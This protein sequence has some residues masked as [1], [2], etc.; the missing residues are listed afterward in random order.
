MSSIANRMPP[1]RT[2]R[3]TVLRSVGSTVLARLAA[4]LV[5]AA[6]GVVVTRMVIDQYGNAAYGQYMLLVSVAALLPFA[7]LGISAA[8]VN[9]TAA[10]DDP[11]RDEYLR[12]TLVSCYRILAVCAVVGLLAVLIISAL[13][14]WRRL[15]GSGLHGRSGALAAALCMVVFALNLLV[16]GGERILTGLRLN[17]V[18]VV[19]RVVQ[20]PI[21]LMALILAQFLGIDLGSFVAVVAYVG[22]FAASLLALL[23]AGRRISPSLRWAIQRAPRVQA[24]RGARVVDTAWPMLVQM[25]ALPVALQSDRVVLSHVAPAADLY[26]YSLASQMFNPMIA[27]VTA[28]AMALWPVY[29]HA[30][31][32]GDPGPASTLGMTWLFAGFGLLGA[33]VI[34]LCSGFLN[35][36]ASGGQIALPPATLLAFTGLVVIQAAKSPLGMYLTDARGLRFQAA[37]SVAM[38]PVNLGLSIALGRVWG[39]PGPVVASIVAVALF[40]LVGNGWYVRRKELL[41]RKVGAG[42]RH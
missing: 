38:L 14:G 24:V 21:V 34:A 40:Q 37:T 6:L 23:L 5:S 19:L 13:G 26:S 25:V 18:A 36:V 2:A 27:V 28:A 29:A 11:R 39:A 30:R 22:T 17:H 32:K 3:G 33:A 16:S 41:E 7:D 8:I 1:A 31:A 4:M 35:D 42:C 20:T 12:R 15:L 10:A 9:A